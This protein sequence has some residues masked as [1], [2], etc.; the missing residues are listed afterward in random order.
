LSTL[1][2]KPGQ[3]VPSNMHF[4]TTDANIRARGGIPTNLVI[5][6][7]FSPTDLHPFK[8]NIDIHKLRTFI[9]QTDPENIPFGMVTITNNAG[10]GQPVSMENLR[11]VSETYHEFGIRFFIDACRYAENA[12]F[13]KLREPGYA[14]KTPL[15]L[16][17]RFLP[18]PTGPMSGKK[19]AS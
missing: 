11:A 15:R 3:F 12:Y 1:L 5:D 4:D 14:H 13:I 18:S 6:E 17:G 16:R 9:E 10:G 19:D 2:V 8:G 7:A